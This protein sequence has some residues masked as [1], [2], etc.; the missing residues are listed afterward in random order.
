MPGIKKLT[1]LVEFSGVVRVQNIFERA[2]TR[3][4]KTDVAIWLQYIAYC[5]ETGSHN[6]LQQIFTRY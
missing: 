3:C 5:K 2:V 4:G 6:K 1:Y